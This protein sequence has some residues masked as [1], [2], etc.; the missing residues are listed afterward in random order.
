MNIKINHNIFNI[1]ILSFVAVFLFSALTVSAQSTG[2][3]SI[4]SRV[5]MS[6]SDTTM[7]MEKRVYDNGL[8]DIIEEVLTGAT[9]DHK[10]L[11]TLHEYDA[12]RR[13]TAQWLPVS[14]SGS[15]GFAAS[16]SLKTTA[17]TQ[18]GDTKPFSS[19]NYDKYLIEEETE[20]FRPG[21][22]W[23]DG[24]KKS[25]IQNT[26]R[27]NEIKLDMPD[28][29]WNTIVVYRNNFMVAKTTD[30]DGCWHEELTDIRG[31]KYAD[32]N[33]SGYT[34]YIYNHCGDLCF[35]IPPAL[36][37]FIRQ[38]YN[39]NSSSNFFYSD[40]ETVKKYAYHYRYDSSHRC[41]YKKLP[42]CEPTYYI[43]DA[44]GNCILSQDGNCRAKGK[45]LFSIPD[46]FGRPCI[47]G[48]CTGTFSYA[49]EP[50]HNSFVYAA[51]SSSTTA[52]LGYTINGMS[53]QG[54]QVHEAFFYDNYSFIGK[55]GCPSSLSYV[56]PS[57]GFPA[58]DATAGRGLNTGHAVAYTD[59]SGIKGTLFTANYYD[60]R[61]RVV[62]SRST[63]AKDG[64]DVLLTEYTF[65]GKPLRT[66]ATH[67][68]SSVS[69]LQELT[70]YAYDHA[71]RLVSV[72]H[73]IGSGSKR[74]LQQNT[75]DSFGR[76]SSCQRFS[77]P[78]L[79]TTYGYN[80]QSALKTLSTGNLFGETLYYQES[81][82]GNTPKYN[83]GI[84]AMSW[85]TDGSGNHRGYRF[86][87]DL[88]S[89]LTSA[90]YLTNG[91]RTTHYDASYSYDSMGNITSLTRNGRQDGGTY[92]KVNQ[93]TYSYDGNRL[94]SVSDAVTSPTYNGF[95]GFCDGA[96]QTVE[97]EYDA[98]GNMTRDRNKGISSIQYNADNLP[99]R[100]QYDN[101]SRATYLY[102]ADGTKLQVRYETSYA[103]LLSSGLPS[104]SA[105]TAI[106]QTHTID[107]VG[108]K[109][110]E[111]GTLKKILVD[112]GYVEYNGG[113]PVYHAYLTD[114]QGNVRVVVDENSTAKQ[115]NHY[116]PY[117]GLMAESTGGDV[118]RYKYNGKELDRMHGLDWY[119]H[120]ARHN[121]A[122]IGRWHSMD[123]KCEKYYDV[124]PYA[125]CGGDPMNS[126]DPDGRSIW[127]KIVKIG[128]KVGA[129]VSRYGWKELGNAATYADAVSDITDNVNTLFDGNA[130]TMDRVVAG[131][132]LASEG[133]PVSFNDAK[134]VINIANG[135]PKAVGRL[136]I[137]IPTQ[138]KINRDLLNPPIKKGQAPTFK[139]D[140]TPVEI[141]HEGQNPN[142]PFRE[143]HMNEHRGKGNDK[144]NH[145]AKDKPTKIDRR[146]FN[147]AK[148]EYWRKEYEKYFKK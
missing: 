145:P 15:G 37:E 34:Y 1:R 78:A 144:R 146:E 61:R 106:A 21:A 135:T 87:Y 50:L 69:G 7:F 76:L 12:Y 73:T 13:H 31:R 130:S 62:Q 70:E 63:N 120:G 122:A 40:N 132:S 68:S 26:W 89:R 58:K 65:T 28:G 23:H 4:S 25:V 138:S 79:K 67:S 105:S 45:W 137:E 44:A 64:T 99:L 143:M 57:Q 94:V 140:G 84:S 36:S 118:Q 124:S 59:H 133:L 48:T 71:E 6:A 93:L 3:S 74:R 19:S 33:A 16:S 80:I 116:Y 125:Y 126:I 83:G 112:G 86:S 142:G 92:G 39:S 66:L 102:T 128:A 111:D 18:Y 22:A 53:L 119:D 131:V 20:R 108:N 38:S 54:I 147:Q 49:D 114:H 109:I 117:G 8:G 35:V 121:D 55:N 134:G 148:K 115:V 98:N 10:D 43:Y 56:L 9:P 136:K 104:G 46:K 123:E 47:S 95:F 27:N 14:V 90:Q 107:Y 75:Y 24:G 97:Y 129:R 32:V 29:T 52:N 141:H 88:K 30:E 60:S 101:G 5:H 113:S 41:I 77:K 2:G 139:K 42:G 103:G 51:Y 96:D 85:S 17:Q 82:G 91:N 110:Y 72:D 81:F 100:I 11:V 127:S